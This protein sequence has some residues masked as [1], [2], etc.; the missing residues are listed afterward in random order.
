MVEYLRKFIRKNNIQKKL[1]LDSQANEELIAKLRDCLQQLEEGN[2]KTLEN[3]MQLH[4]IVQDLLSQHEREIKTNNFVDSQPKP[5]TVG[6]GLRKYSNDK[7]SKSKTGQDLIN[8]ILTE[9][10]SGKLS[11]G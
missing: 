2:K 3:K 6:F 1:R 9:H 7:T 8:N 4:N 10:S 11:S 5:T